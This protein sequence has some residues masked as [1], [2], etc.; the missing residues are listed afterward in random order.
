SALCA[1]APAVAYTLSLHDALPISGGAEQFAGNGQDTDNNGND[2]ILQTNG[3]NPQNTGSAPE[4][5]FAAGGNGTGRGRATPSPV[6]AGYV[7]PSLA[8]SVAQDLAYTLASLSIVV[9]SSWSWAHTLGDVALSGAGF[10]SAAAS[11]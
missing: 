4:P 3:R 11:I 1:Q 7:V 6:Y 2:F 10:A 5:S 8:I 9:P